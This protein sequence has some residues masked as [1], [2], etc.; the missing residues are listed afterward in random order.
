MRVLFWGTPS[1]AVA[2]LQALL[3]AQ[4]GIEVVGV[5]T[6]PD[7][8][9]GRGRRL[10]PSPVGELASAHGIPVLK[11]DRPAGEDFL[12][13]LRALS[14]DLSVVVAYGH[15]LRSEVLDLPPQGSINVHAS[16]L[17]ALR[18]A[19]P[20]HWAI[21]RGDPETG[22]TLMEMT[23][24][25]DAG[26]I[27]LQRSVPIRADH[28]QTTLTDELAVLGGDVLVEGLR[29]WDTRTPVPQDPKDV[30]FAPKVDRQMA[31]VPF[32]REAQA[33]ANHVRAMDAVPG[34]W[35]AWEGSA[36]KL[37]SPEVVATSGETA[38]P[39]TQVGEPFIVATGGGGRV[40]FHEVQP[41]GKRRMSALDWARGR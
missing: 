21:L 34:A 6:Q 8:P 10:R 16:L 14:P 11:P 31:R 30:T 17:P 29:G 12:D 19:A 1:F 33:V 3:D 2:S 22:V 36:L 7:R 38:A 24:G 20:I 13:A 35:M 5:V 9:A 23:P 25:M 28:T 41:A 40:S 27:L 15:I 37:F 4:G 32:E 39:G 26:P 18:G